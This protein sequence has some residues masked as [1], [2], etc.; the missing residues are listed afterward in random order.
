[1]TTLFCAL[2]LTVEIETANRQHKGF[3]ARQYGRA[4]KRVSLLSPLPDTQEIAY[5]ADN[6]N[7][8]R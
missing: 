3:S 1:M 8:E 6:K 2:A 7:F 5:R 4:G